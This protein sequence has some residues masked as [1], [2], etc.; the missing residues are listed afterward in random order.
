MRGS[1]AVRAARRRGPQEVRGGEVEPLDRHAFELPESHALELG[2]DEPRI[3]DQHDREARR[4]EVAARHALDV[5][6][7]DGIDASTIGLE[8]LD[9]EVVEQDVEDLERDGVWRLDGQREVA[10]EVGLR[11]GEF[12]FEHG[13]ALEPE[14]LIDDEPQ[15][16]ASRLGARVGLGNDAAGLLQRLDVG[17]RAVGEAT[18]AAQH[19]L[20]AVGPLAAEHLDGEVEGLVV[21]VLARNRDVADANLGLHRPG[22][23]DHDDTPCRIRRL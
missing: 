1:R 14:E 15:R 21:G 8:V 2:F 3:A 12:Q 6:A 20:D 17:R 11:V 10:R 9:V 13:L 22:T 23:I 19:A 5:V 7:L 4:L 16:L 18:L